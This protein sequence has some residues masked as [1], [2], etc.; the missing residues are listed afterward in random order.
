MT[1]TCN[2]CHSVNFA[3]EQLGRGDDMIRD[4]DHLM[5]ETVAPRLRATVA[6]CEVV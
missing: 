5:A 2:Q 3:K 1:K 4:A 6:Y